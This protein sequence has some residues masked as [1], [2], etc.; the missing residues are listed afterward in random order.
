MKVWDGPSTNIF[1]KCFLRAESR[2]T[3][4]MIELCCMRELYFQ[5]GIDDTSYSVLRGKALV[6]QI[7]LFRSA[8]MLRK[9]Y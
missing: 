7:T 3:K 4:K 6:D 2:P 8:E 9:L 5:I 1:R